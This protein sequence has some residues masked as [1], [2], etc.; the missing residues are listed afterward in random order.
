VSKARNGQIPL[1]L[2]EWGGRRDGAGRPRAPGRR[3][4]VAHEKRRRLSGREPMHV[5]MRLVYGLRSLRKKDTYRVVKSAIEIASKRRGFAVV[6][7]S[8]QRDHLHLLIEARGNGSL[9]RGMQSLSVR[10][11]RN[12]NKLLRRSGPVFADRYHL[13]ILK[14]PRETRSVLLYV[15]NNARRHAFKEGILL[16]PDFVDP[17]SSSWIFDGWT[18]FPPSAKS[19]GYTPPDLPRPESWLLRVGWRNHGSLDIRQVPG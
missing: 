4:T 2:P 1:D 15:L 19:Y 11:A 14:S 13:R 7:Y 3:Q 6:H 8:V 5:T 10:I 18:S 16:A 9:A 17:I 12:L